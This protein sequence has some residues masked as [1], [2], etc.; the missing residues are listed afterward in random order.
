MSWPVISLSAWV[1]LHCKQ[2]DQM[3]GFQQCGHV[4]L[5]QSTEWGDYLNLGGEYFYN[6]DDGEPRLL[7]SIKF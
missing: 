3:G 4:L 1:G 7:C 2:N 5:D 6:R